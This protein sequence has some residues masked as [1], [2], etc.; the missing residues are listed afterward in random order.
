[1][2]EFK[3]DTLVVMTG[4]VPAPGFTL[5]IPIEG[6]DGPKHRMSSFSKPGRHGVEV[7]AQFYDDR[8]VNLTGLIYG[9]TVEEFEANRRALIRAV[10]IK[11]DD[12]GYPLPTRV[13]FTTMAGASYYV[14]V[15]FDKPIMNME[16]PIDTTYQVTG[17]CADPFIFGDTTVTSAQIRPPS[18]GGYSVPMIVPYISDASVGGSI[19]L[20]NVGEETAMPVITLTG[21]LTQPVI[22]NQTTGKRL[23][24]NYTLPAG[25]TMTI[26]MSR[27]LIIRSGASQI[28]A[29]TIASDWWGIAPGTNTISVMS[30]SSSD[31]G[32]AVLT[33][34]PP[35]VGV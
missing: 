1:M 23:E 3:I 10:A 20:T 9:E 34:N 16:S 25:Q 13:T 7:S 24:L 17:V 2:Q 11:K 8:L 21:L 4:G 35:Y 31:S 22:T 6:L 33:F 28:G 30:M 14:D 18:G 32:Y 27:Q 29:K 19:T 5:S 15:F 12:D 26:D